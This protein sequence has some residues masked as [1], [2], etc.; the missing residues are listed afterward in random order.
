MDLTSARV[1]FSTSATGGAGTCTA[2]YT[3][4]TDQVSLLNDAGSGWQTGTPG[5]GTL[6]NS[7]CLIDLASSTATISGDDLILTLTVTFSHTF[8]G[9][10]NVYMLAQS[11]G[12]KTGWQQQGTWTVPE[13][14]EALSV[15]P[16]G[17]IGR[18][19]TFVLAYSDSFGVT[20]DLKAASVRFG[21]TDEAA[22]ACTVQYNAMT[23]MVRLQN[24]GAI[25]GPWTPF[26]SGTLANSQCTLNL[27]LGGAAASGTNLTLSLHLTF[28]PAFAGTKTISMRASSNL[29]P[30]TGW[31]T[32]GTWT[33]GTAVAAIS[34]APNTGGAPPGVTQS[35]VLAYSDS[36]GVEADLRSARVRFRPS[37]G[38]GPQCAIDYDAM[39]DR[40]RLQ[41]DAG[42][43]GPFTAFGSGTLANSQCTL[44]LAQSG[45]VRSGTNLTLTLSL[46]FDQSFTGVKNIDMRANSNA[47]PTTGWVRRGVWTVR[48]MAATI[49]FDALAG[50]TSRPFFS[51]SESGFTVT[52]IQGRWSISPTAI[53]KATWVL[54]TLGG[55]RTVSVTAGGSPFRFSSINFGC[56]GELGRFGGAR[57]DFTGLRNDATVFSAQGNA[58]PSFP[59]ETIQSPSAAAIDTLLIRLTTSATDLDCSLD[60]IVLLEE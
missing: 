44:D 10:K 15:T 51:H 26:G 7:Q 2:S 8:I 30:T 25:P 17:G 38:S 42:V 29:G 28:S 31:V 24:D 58:S 33:V 43:W 60:D 6:Q 16:S 32:R 27:A 39:T 57:Y 49:S 55:D 50:D 54:P 45:A 19:Q 5:A 47:G 59:L 56:R 3:P 36:E 37:S 53:L 4:S 14:V 21:T 9:A 34:A 11:G 40:V 12:T 1:R 48:A 18:T 13:V 52:A 22:G 41:N 20:S 46:T 35:F 23:D